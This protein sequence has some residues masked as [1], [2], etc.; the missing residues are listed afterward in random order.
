MGYEWNFGVVLKT[1][2]FILKGVT[3]TLLL[4]ALGWGLGAVIGILVAI[5]RLAKVPVLGTLLSIYVDVFRSLPD[6]VVLFWF[7]YA[8][9]ILT[10]LS[11]S[12]LFSASLALGIAAGAS[13]SE[14][15]RSGIL[16]ISKGQWEAS[17]ALGMTT[18]QAYRR[19]I[20]PQAIVRMLP[21]LVSTTISMVK[22]SS[23]ASAVGVAELM[24]QGTAM[25]LWT[26]RR[27]EVY[28]IIA[29]V[30]FVL[31]Y[32]QALFVNHIHARLL[33]KG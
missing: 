22:A 20:L 17:F 26:Y 14:I 27:V 7:F 23:L 10:G 4:S 5:I 15:F 31:T 25:M 9:P 32:P 29:I 28:T 16:S 33:P 19:I 2:P 8:I 21:P 6:L 24:W 12:A 1:L 11:T 3:F 18:P 13:L 30:Y